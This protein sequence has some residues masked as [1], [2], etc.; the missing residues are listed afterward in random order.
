MAGTIYDPIEITRKFVFGT[1]TPSPDNYNKHIRPS[2]DKPASIG[3]D[4]ATYMNSGGGRF[5]YPSLFPAVERFFSGEIPDR[6]N[7]YTAGEI[8]GILGLTSNDLRINISQYGTGIGTEDHAER[9]WI[10]GNSPFEL[11]VTNATFYVNNGIKKIEG[12][13]VR[14]RPDN[15]DFQSVGRA[16][17]LNNFVFTPILDRYR[18]NRGEVTINFTGSS[19]KPY[20]TYTEEDFLANQKLEADVNGS[21]EVGYAVLGVTGLGY[22]KNIA[23]DPFLSYRRGF[24]NV[25]YGSP[26][27]DSISSAGVTQ[28]FGPG[29]VVG[30]A[31]NDELRGGTFDDE[32][33]GGEGIDKAVYKGNKG[34]YDIENLGDGSVRITD[35]VPSRDG[36]DILKNIEDIVFGKQ[37]LAQD[38]AFVIDTTDSMSDDIDEVKARASD[39]INAI[40]G[41]ESSVSADKKDTR[42]SRIA[43]VGYNDPATNTF[44]PFTDQPDIQ[45][46]KT[47]ALNAINSISVGG[48][49]DF[50]EVVNAGLIRALSGDA[51]QWRADADVRRIILFGDA[52]PKDTELRAQVLALASNVGNS[53]SASNLGSSKSIAG[54]IKTSNIASNL[55]VTRFALQTD[56][57]VKIPVEI[58]TILI[59]NDRKTATDFE[60]LATA[61]DG[62]AFKAADASEIV[63]V[64]IAALGTSADDQIP[65]A[66]NQTVSITTP[67]QNI[68]NGSPSDDRLLGYRGNNILIGLEGNDTL[69]GGK[70]NDI[71]DG[72]IGDDRLWG[73]LGQDLLIGGPGSDTFFITGNS[74]LGLPEQADVITDFQ[75]GDTIG[76]ASGLLLNQ[77]VFEPITLQLNGG[78]PTV[79]TA[80]RLDKNYLAIVQGVEKSTLTP[81]VFIGV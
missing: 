68:I 4:M 55:A 71:L 80:I 15:F 62:K 56:D 59:G 78:L 51:G 14:A 65:P 66:K 34:E 39:I 1:D 79:S 67:T 33:D 26:G 69:Y 76:L 19:G 37:I 31:G 29:L 58:F 48:G 6:E 16:Q 20:P 3:Y 13:E 60:S 38:I 70:E 11:N 52:P 40:F 28:L 64:I 46:R 25:I 49:D 32:L 27:N 5:A 73:D 63:D 72:G 12:L 45:Q 53:V 8:G 18:L 42:G 44:L 81:N 54:D 77:L 41:E 21:N 43:V 17:L 35:K 10:F 2:N 61:T 22:F 36:S 74:A 30:G 7:G 47:A 9:S 75:P 24:F 50:P 57:R 23:S